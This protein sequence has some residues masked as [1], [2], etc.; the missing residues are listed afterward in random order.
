[1]M[2]L[3]LQEQEQLLQ[4]NPDFSDETKNK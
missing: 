2:K 4:E 3:L 1:M